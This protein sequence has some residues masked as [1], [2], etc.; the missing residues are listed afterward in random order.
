MEKADV[1]QDKYMIYRRLG[2]KEKAWI[3]G[4]ESPGHLCPENEEDV[5]VIGPAGCPSSFKRSEQIQHPS[6][7]LANV[8]SIPDERDGYITLCTLRGHRV[9]LITRRSPL[10][11][12]LRKHLVD[13]LFT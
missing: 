2:G 11:N 5:E 13:E 9:L 4:G 6:D 7:G 1:E 8:Q 3:L 10:T 12:P